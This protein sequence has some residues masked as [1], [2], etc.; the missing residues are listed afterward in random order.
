MEDNKI[1]DYKIIIP[2]GENLWIMPYLEVNQ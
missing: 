2:S 1:I